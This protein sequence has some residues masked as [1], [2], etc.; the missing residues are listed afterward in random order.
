MSAMPADLAPAAACRIA[1]RA[2][3]GWRRFARGG[4]DLWTKGYGRVADGEALLTGLVKLPATP[5][6][7]DISAL[8][9]DCDGHFA[10]AACGPGWAI[11]AVDNVRSIPLAF[12]RC[13]GEWCIDDRALRLR[14]KAKLSQRDIDLE[15]ALALGMAGYTIDSAT[16]YR[17]LH[18]VGP[19]ELVLFTAGNQPQRHRYYFYRPWRADK[20]AYDPVRAGKSLA[21]ITL[22]VI[23]GMMKSVGGRTLVVPL[24]GGRDSRLI[25][26]AAHRLGYRNIRTFAYGQRGNHDANASRAIAERLGLPWRFTPSTVSTMRHYFQETHASYCAFADS[27]QAV[28]FVQDLPQ[29]QALKQDG[30]IPTDAVFVNG[31]TGDYLSGGHIVPD[32]QAIALDLPRQ[33]RLDRIAAALFK[34]HFALWTVL[35]TPANRARIKQQHL[36]ALDRAG[37]A[38]ADPADDYGLY[39]YAE[40][41][42]RQCKYVVAGQR[43]YEYLGHDWRLPLWDKAYLDFFER[44]PLEGKIGQRLYA[45][46]LEIENWGGVWRNLPVNAKTIRPHWLRPIRFAAKLALAPLGRDAWHRFERRYFQYWMEPGSQIVIRN[47]DA[48]ARDRRGARHGVAWLTEA[49]LNT[50]G[51]SYDGAPALA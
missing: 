16:L 9:A 50:H 47:Y 36:A 10:V 24:S 1:I 7:K 29:I 5:T 39:E 26:S 38:L 20:P 11:A 21:E 46:M 19:G 3:H 40:F 51:L 37:A 2:E 43:I 15:A 31:S 14:G 33:E 35:Q 48:V 42:D 4:L 30:Y 41:Q 13:D 6:V 44:V 12:A 23:D 32:I 25:V 27:L 8:I 49:Y 22:A 28:P 17:G 45:D 18:Q 34:K